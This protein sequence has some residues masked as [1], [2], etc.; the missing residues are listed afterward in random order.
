MSLSL[1][2][3]KKIATLSHLA[4]SE[5][6]LADAQDKLNNVF[7]LIGKMQATPTEGVVPMSHP[8]E[9]SLRLREDVVSVDITRDEYQKIAPEVQDGLYLVPKVIE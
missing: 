6:E 7:E 8:Q 5:A 3:V 4:F 1:E 9:Q 2:D